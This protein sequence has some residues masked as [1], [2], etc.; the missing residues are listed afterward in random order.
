MPCPGICRLATRACSHGQRGSADALAWPRS[1]F[2]T[3]CLRPQMANC[4]RGWL[5]K[6]CWTAAAGMEKVS[7][8]AGSSVCFITCAAH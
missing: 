4:S 1:S 3:S 8:Q 7:F 6:A 5:S 2:L